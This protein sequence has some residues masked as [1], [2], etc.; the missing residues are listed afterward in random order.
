MAHGGQE[1]G[2]GFVGTVGRAPGILQRSFDPLA[3]TDVAEGAEHHVF[4]FVA[5]WRTAEIE[6][7]AITSFEI[8]AARHTG[9]GKRLVDPRRA[10]RCAGFAQPALG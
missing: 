6:M 5:G 3:R 10:A 9:Y 2:F 7:P 8:I 1:L 4:A